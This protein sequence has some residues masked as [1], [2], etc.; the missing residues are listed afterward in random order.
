MGGMMPFVTTP[1]PSPTELDLTSPWVVSPGIE[2]FTMFAILGVAVAL[3]IWAMTRSIRRANFRAAE[4]EEEL[5]GPEA[6]SKASG[7]AA[8]TAAAEAA[9]ADADEAIREGLNE[10][11]GVDDSTDRAADGTT[12]EPKAD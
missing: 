4:R 3:L 6:G 8:S 5:Y 1:E 2:G 9:G 12:G 10:G 11:V 7:A